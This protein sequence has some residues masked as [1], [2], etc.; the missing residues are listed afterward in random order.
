M[1]LGGLLA[2]PESRPAQQ[3][4]AYPSLP[5]DPPPPIP[6]PPWPVDVLTLR[7]RSCNFRRFAM[8]ELSSAARRRHLHLPVYR[9]RATNGG[10]VRRV[11]CRFHRPARLQL[12]RRSRTAT[13]RRVR[14]AMCRLVLATLSSASS[15]GGVSS[16][17][18]RARLMPQSAGAAVEAPPAL[19]VRRCC[20]R[21]SKFCEELLQS[22][23]RD[24]AIARRSSFL[25]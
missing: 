17:R 10:A 5:P 9:A 22:A 7:A 18:P 4:L 21:A 20:A 23:R 3:A 6:R 25:H 8:T 16:P 14:R 15:E 11:R 24:M 2:S 12:G 1:R 19:A 13:M